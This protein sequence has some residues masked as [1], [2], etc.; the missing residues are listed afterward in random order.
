MR[1]PP[2]RAWVQVCALL[3][4]RALRPVAMAEALLKDMISISFTGLSA[5][6]RTKTQPR[7]RG[8]T[9]RRR[10]KRPVQT[11]LLRSQSLPAR[12]VSLKSKVERLMVAVVMRIWHAVR[13]E[14]VSVRA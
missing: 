8:Q 12:P 5:G 1:S 3:T 10:P 9:G 4:A 6:E 2:I 7:E 11:R 13:A 14:H